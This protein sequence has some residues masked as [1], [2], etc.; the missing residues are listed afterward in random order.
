MLQG[1][2]GYNVSGLT[3]FQVTELQGY[4]IT[5]LAMLQGFRDKEFQGCVISGLQSYAIS[6]LQG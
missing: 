6:G 2:Q 4:T 3:M 1:W 5:K